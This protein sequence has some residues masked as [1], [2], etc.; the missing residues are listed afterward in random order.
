MTA[1]NRVERHGANADHPKLRP[2]EARLVDHD[3]QSFVYLR[4]PLGLSDRSV[5]VPWAMAP[6]LALC[7]GSRTEGELRA[8]LLFRTGLD[9]P[10]AQVQAVLAGLDEALL[11]ENDAFLRVSEKALSA[12]RRAPSRPVSREGLVFPS[13]PEALKT[14]LDVYGSG[15]VDATGPSTARGRLAGVVSPHIDFERGGETYARLWQACAADLQGVERVIVF[16]TDHAGGPGAITP[17][18]QNYA[19]PLGVLPTDRRTVDGLADVLGRDHAFSEELHHVNEHSIELALVW[20]HHQMGGRACPV[21]P[22]LCGSFQHFIDG[23]E[24]VRESDAID[25]TVS[26][27]REAAAERRTLVLAAADLAHVGP[28][29]GDPAPIDAAR[30]SEVA[31]RDAASIA[32]ICDG[33][34]DAFLALS[35]AEGDARRVCGISPIYMALRCLDGVRGESVGYAQ[36]PADADGGSLVSIVGVSLYDRV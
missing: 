6:L 19:T 36:C 22:V 13:E 15:V 4:D 25:A 28:A 17:T 32:A 5:L 27:L 11:L 21:V 34:A 2:V 29:F 14:A 33:D 16:G 30:R 31:A 35:I 10:A 7:D 9:L 3:G 20:L 24:D 18:A 8:A 26:Y 12:Y 23:Q 1:P